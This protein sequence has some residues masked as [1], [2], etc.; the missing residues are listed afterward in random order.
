MLDKPTINSM[1]H[2]PVAERMP[3]EIAPGVFWIGDCLLQRHKGK[4]Y[5]GYNAAFLVC[6]D[7]ASILVETGHP[8]DF[9]VIERHLNELFAQGV[10]PLRLRNIVRTFL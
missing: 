7:N 4:V 9:P 2:T 6:G 1:I 10:A 8:K 5:H 3:R